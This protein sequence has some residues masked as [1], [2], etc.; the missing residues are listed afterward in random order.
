M[1]LIFFLK[2]IQLTG[3]SPSWAFFFVVCSSEDRPTFQEIVDRLKFFLWTENSSLSPLTWLLSISHYHSQRASHTVSPSLHDVCILLRWFLTTT[4]HCLNELSAWTTPLLG[5]F[6]NWHLDP[7]VCDS[8]VG[9]V[10]DYPAKSIFYN[11]ADLWLLMFGSR[12][13]STLTQELPPIATGN[14]LVSS[15][16]R[17]SNDE[18]FL[19]YLHFRGTNWSLYVSYACGRQCVSQW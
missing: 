9:S 5:V 3:A 1:E 13:G 6:L 11:M 16:Y 19:F 15:G 18:R 8:F 7:N 4:T 14:W 10:C 2:F 12:S 17:V